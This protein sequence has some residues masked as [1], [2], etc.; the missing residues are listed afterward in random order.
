MKRA[1]VLLFVLLGASISSGSVIQVP[2]EQPTIQDGIDAAS[3]G[4]TVL[5]ADGTYYENLVADKSISLIS[6][7]GA[8]NTTISPSVQ[9]SFIL[10]ADGIQA[11]VEGFSFT[12]CAGS[13]SALHF[14]QCH[15]TLVGCKITGNSTGYAPVQ[16]WGVDGEF[17]GSFVVD[18]CDFIGNTDGSRSGGLWIVDVTEPSTV[19]NCRFYDNSADRGGGTNLWNSDNVT[20]TRCVYTN[21]SV[22]RW[23]GAIH[24]SATNSTCN[25]L[26]NTIVANLCTDNTGGGIYAASAFQLRN[27][28]ITSNSGYGIHSEGSVPVVNYND[29]WDN[30]P[31]DYS[32]LNP[33]EYDISLSPQFVDTDNY[34]F[35][36]STYSPCIDAGDPDQIYNDPDGTRND[37]GA[38]PYGFYRTPFA[39]NVNFGP[40]ANGEY[41]PSIIPE[42]FWSYFDTLETTQTRYWIE[43]GTDPDWM[44]AEMWSTSAVI[45][46]DTHAIYAGAQLNEQQRY[47]LRIKVHNGIEWGRWAYTYFTTPPLSDRINVPSDFETIQ[48]AIGFA[49][50]TDS[51]FVWPGVY[52]EALDYLGKDIY[53]GSTNGPLET[54]ITVGTSS[55]LVE[56]TNGEGP[57]A[58]L[59]GFT[60]Q[61]G[62]IGVY[63][64]GASPTIRRN[65]FIG[66]NVYGAYPGWGAISIRGAS[67]ATVVNNTVLFSEHGGILS[68]SSLVPVFKNNIVCFSDYYGI[69]GESVAPACSYNN[70]FGN[71]YDFTGLAQPGVGAVREDPLLDSNYNLMPQSPCIDSGDPDPSYNDPDGS[72]NDIGAVPFGWYG[73]PLAF[74]INFGPNSN[75]IYVPT[76][77]PVFYWSFVD[78][79]ETTQNSYWI[80]AGTDRDW[81]AAEMW[82][83]GQVPSSDTFAVYGGNALE[84]HGIYYVRIKVHNGTQWGDWR[85]AMV[86]P[87]IVTALYV[88]ADYPTIQEAVSHA[89]GG[90]SIFVSPGTY[91]E[92]VSISN[93]LCLIGEDPAT[94]TIKAQEIGHVVTVAADNV[95]IS[96]FTITRDGYG[97]N[98]SGIAASNSD[99]FKLYG[100]ILESYSREGLKVSHS[101]SVLIRGNSVSESRFG[102]GVYLVAC[103]DARVDS[104]EV[105]NHDYVGISFSACAGV[106]AQHNTVNNNGTGIRLN[107][108]CDLATN[109]IDGNLI[110]LCQYGVEMP[111]ALC[112][113][114]SNNLIQLNGVGVY[115]HTGSADNEVSANEIVD[116]ALGL[117]VAA[118]GNLIYGNTLVNDT[119]ATDIEGSIWDNGYPEGGNFWSDYEGQD[120]YSGVNQDSPGSDGIGDS[121]YYVA[122]TAGSL[123]NYP[124]ISGPLSVSAVG[125]YFAFIGDP[126]DFQAI[127]SGGTAPYT[128]LW[129]FGDDETSVEKNPTHTY[130]TPGN[131]AVVL[132]VTDA[133]SNSALDTAW[134]YVKG[135]NPPPDV[136][137]PFGPDSVAFYGDYWFGASTSDP[138]G[139]WVYYQFEWG[140][141]DT[142]EWFGAYDSG[143]SC[144]A[145]HGWGDLGTYEFKVRAKDDW[146]ATSEWSAP[147]VVEVIYVKC[148]DFNLTGL[149]DVDDI[150]YAIAYVFQGGPSPLPWPCAGEVDGDSGIDIGDIVYL[151]DYVFMSGPA[152]DEECCGGNP[153][154]SPE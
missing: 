19:S 141:G 101:D 119:N 4:D 8:T 103:E 63:C 30:Y 73:A 5:V 90:D 120:L 136:P 142:T 60:L 2:S 98:Y 12:G 64:D 72:R 29:L 50:D 69:H 100:N 117:H 42:I 20:I 39:D 95:E 53:V 146:G 10:Y 96:G 54:T 116:N 148:G 28:I 35:S 52:N 48:G 133:D 82:S 121:A 140:D 9:D 129:D 22:A 149:I 16:L 34:D 84:D 135:D 137:T 115:L 104:N 125:F 47:Y 132:T 97:S 55:N 49:G 153:L 68:L 118:S 123:D 23:G 105:F 144:Y 108:V 3:G 57:G 124:L 76:L 78:S 110:E 88:P 107:T 67:T 85:E 61:G 62:N 112:A 92:N 130:T 17:E 37:M 65:R 24:C 41:V 91:T 87:R 145:R 56:F 14:K 138:D 113:R 131:Y 33:G 21:N 27:N 109:V 6:V 11:H 75:G 7:N 106:V 66:Q 81:T 154:G 59:E 89:L 71:A 58:V 18:S 83:T 139:D 150:V 134:A 43:V 25:I 152:P 99:F 80:E 40:D 127:A 128:Y 79:L 143:D 151:I 114:L 38:I 46:A 94:T 51:I 122:G 102:S 32:G 70:C 147:F 93:A 77:T 44:V 26:N 15:V 13:E 86:V 1:V 45:S 36:L 31:E 74:D 111:T 126:L